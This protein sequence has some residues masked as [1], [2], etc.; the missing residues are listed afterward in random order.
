MTLVEEIRV[1]WGWTGLIPTEIVGQNDFGNLI[2]RDAEGLYWRICPEELDCQ[3]IANIREQLDEL[4][5]NQDFLS[6]W[7]MDAVAELAKAKFG[8]LPEGRKFCLKIPGV[9]GGKYEE[10]NIGTISSAE[11]IRS[12][13]F[14]L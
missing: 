2:V 1:A 4:A 6:D 10:N 5:A 13:D 14:W 3:V 9:L 8:E 12:L 7:N 11:L